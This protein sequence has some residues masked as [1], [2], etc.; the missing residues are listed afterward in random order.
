M[1]FVV[2]VKKNSKPKEP[3]AEGAKPADVK[4]VDVKP[5]PI[6]KEAPSP[7]K[8]IIAEIAKIE[9][10]LEKVPLLVDLSKTYKHKKCTIAATILGIFLVAILIVNDIMAAFLVDILSYF[11][12]AYQS[13]KSVEKGEKGQ[14]KQWLSYWYEIDLIAR[15]ILNLMNFT[16]H[17]KSWLFT[18]FPYYYL[19]KG[20]AVIWLMTPHFSV[21]I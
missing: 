10:V 3:A 9:K 11:Y 7:L 18:L 6:K 8:M 12:P 5:E 4:P 16:E 20:L 14:Y 17:W 19:L 13:V 21:I 15:V 2:K 1:S